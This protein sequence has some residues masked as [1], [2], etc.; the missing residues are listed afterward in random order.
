MFFTLHTAHLTQHTT[1]KCMLQ[2]VNAPRILVYCKLH[3]LFLGN[4]LAFETS[5]CKYADFIHN[6]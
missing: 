3:T 6:K 5:L 4:E 1:T 2:N